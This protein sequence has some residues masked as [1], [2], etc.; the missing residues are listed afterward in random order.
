MGGGAWWQW[1]SPKT[2]GGEGMGRARGES[3]VRASVAQPEQSGCQRR[4]LVRA[5]GATRPCTARRNDRRVLVVPLGSRAHERSGKVA[6]GET[7]RASVPPACPPAWRVSDPRAP[8]KSP[9]S[10]A[11]SAGCA[12]ARPRGS[13]VHARLPARG[14]QTSRHCRDNARQQAPPHARWWPPVCQP[15]QP[16]GGP[17][18]APRGRSGHTRAALGRLSALLPGGA[19][20]PVVAPRQRCVGGGGGAGRTCGCE[21]R[22]GGARHPTVASDRTPLWAPPAAMGIQQGG[23]WRAHGRTRALPCGGTTGNYGG[24]AERSMRRDS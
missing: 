23:A 19:H 21:P 14:D 22:K 24:A 11:L 12:R 13:R 10:N 18:E 2:S 15:G 20:T 7:A 8:L 1:R 4:Q 16:R 6:A 5:S 9:P 3:R 17:S